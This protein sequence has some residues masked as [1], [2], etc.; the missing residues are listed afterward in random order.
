VAKFRNFIQPSKH[1]RMRRE[2]LPIQAIPA[3]SKLND[4]SFIDIGVQDLG[5][6]KGSGLVTTR[7]LSSKDTYDIPTLL[8]IPHDLILSAEAIEEHAKVDQ[9]FRELLEAAGGKVSFPFFLIRGILN[10]VL[11]NASNENLVFERGCAFVLADADYDR[12][13]E[14]CWYPKP[15]DRVLQDAS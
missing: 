13:R 6:D 15:V 4:V 7:A 14:W 2:H 8:A 9:H 10:P 1:Q 11:E 5:A 12:C 3:W